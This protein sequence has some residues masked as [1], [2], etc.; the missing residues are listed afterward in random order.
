MRRPSSLSGPQT[1][2]IGSGWRS[3]GR[4]R[5]IAARARA[6]SVFGNVT[7]STTRARR[8]H[9]LVTVEKVHGVRLVGDDGHFR[10]EGRR[11]PQGDLGGPIDEGGQS[12][13]DVTAV[14]RMG[15]SAKASRHRYRSQSHLR[16]LIF[17]PNGWARI[18]RYALLS[19]SRE[20]GQL[21]VGG[22]VSTAAQ[23]L[24]RRRHCHTII[25]Q[26]SRSTGAKTRIRLML[27]A[28]SWLGMARD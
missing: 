4:V 7:A 20:R 24:R 21:L 22:R 10:L 13:G 19:R 26:R 9:Y 18:T 1:K 17:G 25:N 27:H 2:H 14:G 6:R 3:A 11:T 12:T 5:A 16:H 15:R 28:M 23:I 8:R